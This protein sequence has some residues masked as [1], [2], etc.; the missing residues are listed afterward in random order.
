MERK[1][2][3]GRVIIPFRVFSLNYVTFGF[4]RKLWDVVNIQNLKYN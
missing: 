4:Q 1:M 3:N 2:K